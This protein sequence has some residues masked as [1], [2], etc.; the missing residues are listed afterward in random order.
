MVIWPLMSI[1]S[2][3]AVASEVFSF[4][5]SFDLLRLS[6][7]RC[8]GISLLE[9]SF[10]ERSDSV[11]CYTIS[12]S[13]AALR[14]FSGFRVSSSMIEMSP[15]RLP[16]SY[17]F[18]FALSISCSLL[19]LTILFARLPIF[20]FKLLFIFMLFF[21]SLSTWTLIGFWIP[22]GIFSTKGFCTGIL[23]SSSIK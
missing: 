23:A 14:D 4:F 1:A 19:S 21:V 17:Y 10:L 20:D 9:L 22:P 15:G 3:T 2:V 8:E 13:S 18:A 7:F 16:F 5:F 6:W 11:A 12:F